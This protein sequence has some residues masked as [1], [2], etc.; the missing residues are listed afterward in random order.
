M[1]RANVLADSNVNFASANA[2]SVPLQHPDQA[3]GGGTKQLQSLR[4]QSCWKVRVSMADFVADSS[5]GFRLIFWRIFAGFPVGF[6]WKPRQVLL[7]NF[8]KPANKGLA[9]FS[10]NNSPRNSRTNS[11]CL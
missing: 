10:P 4:D 11:P 5:A 7:G 1:V 9:K 6:A 2:C 8:P 3:R